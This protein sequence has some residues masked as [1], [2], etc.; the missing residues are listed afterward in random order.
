MDMTS[1]RPQE[2]NFGVE[3]PPQSGNRLPLDPYRLLQVGRSASGADIR[4]AY[5]GRCADFHPDKHPVAWATAAAQAFV[6]V[7]DAYA[8]LSDPVTRAAYDENRE[9]RGARDWVPAISG[10]PITTALRLAWDLRSLL[11]FVGEL[12]ALERAHGLEEGS[13]RVATSANC[14]CSATATAPGGTCATLPLPATPDR[15]NRGVLCTA[16]KLVHQCDS[17]CTSPKTVCPMW[18]RTLVES[19]RATVRGAWVLRTA[20]DTPTPTA[21]PGRQYWFNPCAGISAWLDGSTV[22]PTDSTD[23]TTTPEEV[24]GAAGAAASQPGPSFE[25]TEST[26]VRPPLELGVTPHVCEPGCRFTALDGGVWV[27]RASSTPH[28]CTP[29]Q[30]RWQR[31]PPPPPTPPRAAPTRH[32]GEQGLM[33]C[34]ATDRPAYELDV[35]ENDDEVTAS[36]VRQSLHTATY[37]AARLPDAKLGKV[38]WVRCAAPSGDGECLQLVEIEPPAPDLTPWKHPLDAW[39]HRPSARQAARANANAEKGVDEKESNSVDTEVGASG[40]PNIDLG[41]D[42]EVDIL[43]LQRAHAVTVRKRAAEAEDHVR[44]TEQ[45]RGDNCEGERKVRRTEPQASDWDGHTITD[46]IMKRDDDHYSDFVFARF[47]DDGDYATGDCLDIGGNLDEEAE[48]KA[49]AAIA[50]EAGDRL[51]YEAAEEATHALAAGVTRD[52][53]AVAINT[54]ELVPMSLEGP[55]DSTGAATASQPPPMSVVLATLSTA[56]HRARPIGAP[57]SLSAERAFRAAKPEGG[58]PGNKSHQRRHRQS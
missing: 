5:L 39:S 7:H 10:D 22:K 48:V 56:E 49:S 41:E 12:D 42:A 40:S 47:E 58:T 38:E 57:V 20:G 33:R 28:L 46:S 27:C 21:F 30:C 15:P 25:M 6:A 44:E 52:R 53:L 50:A 2:V 35:E 4:A 14:P 32:E 43:Q 13:L 55:S 23:T 3:F 37:V 51:G 18:A 31:R 24:A 29:S 54:G 34:W 9:A 36:G 11:P 8:L 19:Y 45:T 1:E 16:H 17:A 26:S